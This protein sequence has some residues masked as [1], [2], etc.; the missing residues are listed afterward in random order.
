MGISWWIKS[1]LTTSDVDFGGVDIRDAGPTLI[2]R[3]TDTSVTNNQ[4]LGQIKFLHSD[5]GGGFSEVG[6][7]KSATTEDFNG[8]DADSYKIHIDSNTIVNGSLESVGDI[9]ALRIFR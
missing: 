3:D 2:L 8:V 4:V 1:V 7:I 9:V 6:I 5:S